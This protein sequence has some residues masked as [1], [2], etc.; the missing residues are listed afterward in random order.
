[1]RVE[2]VRTMNVKSKPKRRGYTA[3]KR[4][5]WKKAVVQLHPEDSIELF[6]GQ[7]AMT[8][9]QPS[10]R[11]PIKQAQAHLAGPP[12]RHLGRPRRG[13]QDR[14]RE[15]AHRGAAR[16][17]AG[18][19]PTAASP[20]AT[21]AAGPS[22]ATARSTSSARR[23]ACPPASPRS[24]TTRTGAPTSRCCTTPTATSA[25]SSRRRGCASARRSS[26]A[27][28]PTS[29]RA[30]PAAARDPDRHHGAQRRAHARPRRPDGPLRRARRS[31]SWRRR[32]SA[33]R[34]AC[35]PARCGWCAIECRA[36]VGSI[37]N[38]E[39]QNIDL[40]KAGRRRHKGK[41]PQTRGTAM[42]PVDHPHGGGE[43]ST[44]AGRHPVTP[45]GVPTLGYRTRKKSKP[46]DRVDRARP[47]A[48]QARGER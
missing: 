26:P 46:S 24:S 3:G 47:P 13:D 42:N 12:L 36:T 18:A 9:R 41:R 40:G 37:G 31:S 2:G 29:S 48:R 23:T 17:P 27:S 6:E 14:A 1:M 20:R 10:P 45:W 44:T 7:E 19:T 39:H 22:A 8:S 16:S 21:A 32:A 11:W 28:A 30:T 15:G 35:P 5:R 43:G 33:R 34:C 38:A 4:R 25:T